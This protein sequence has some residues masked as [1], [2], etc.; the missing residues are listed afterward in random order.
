M[1]LT[2]I[3]RIILGFAAL[4]CLLL[5]TSFLSYFGLLDIRNSAETVVNEKMPV[6]ARI[7]EFQANALK[8]A[9]ITTNGFHE[10]DLSLLNAN[11]TSY[12]QSEVL[13]SENFESLRQ[14][15]PAESIQGLSQSTAFLN[16]SQAMYQQREQHLLLENR[17]SSLG[18]EVLLI[19]DEASALMLD[20]S[21]LEGDD[22]SLPTLIGAGTSIDNKLAPML[23]GIKEL[24]ASDD[25]EMTERIIGDLE[26][27]ISNIQVDKD[28]IN[29][30]AEDVDDEGLVSLFN[31]QYDL[32]K[33]QLERSDGLFALQRQKIIAMDS[34]V[35]SNIQARE[36]LN[37]TLSG[38]D[39]LFADI[40]E[41]TLQG[42]NDILDNVQLNVTKSIIISIVGL[43]AVVGLAVLAT[44]SI[45]TP[46]SQINIGLNKII[47]GDLTQRLNDEGHCEFSNLA[48]K[49]N[50]LSDS[51][52]RLVGNI[53]D[54]ELALEDVTR[55]SGELSQRSL[56][57]V[58]L[59]REKIGETAS[60][61]HEV[62]LKSQSTVQQIGVSLSQLREANNQSQSMTK[63]LT[64]S[65]EQVTG[66]AKQAEHSA[67]I[68][69]RLDENSRNIGSILDVIKTIAEQTNLLALNA[70]IEAARAGEQ[71]RGFAVVADEVRTL[72]TRT[73]NSTE[74]IEKMIGSLQS[75]AQ[76]AVQAIDDG[77]HQAHESVQLTQQVNHQVSEI[78]KIVN[79]LSEIN[80]RISHETREQDVLLEEAAGSLEQIVSL[81]D[82]AADSTK[83]SAAV[84]SE[85]EAQMSSLKQA[86]DRFK[87]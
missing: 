38:I 14:L 62:R 77:K 24:S 75:D 69:A 72:A 27:G 28:Y 85:I 43:G 6:Q 51:L 67:T 36:A 41:D 68:I 80:E 63:L 54:Q 83:Q 48:K 44:R 71:G 53:H 13:F 17:I 76:H 19:A 64:E 49:V 8:L 11:K 37:A 35:Q 12:E 70:A 59:Q 21:Y 60:N 42:Q 73:Q 46:L 79:E 25:G 15:L 56:Q 10:R 3:Q 31:E 40:S 47:D 4:G 87:V 58:D 7:I 84:T 81:A 1:K 20:L 23:S 74:E 50:E 65:T 29:R 32:L 61:T 78:T 34:A 52:R 9:N 33:P 30:L 45:T 2:V 57:Q 26:Y 39:L 22:P 82:E 16:L 86:V 66:Q 5:L 18:E 55:R